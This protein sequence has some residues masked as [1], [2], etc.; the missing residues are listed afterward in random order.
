MSQDLKQL[1]LYLLWSLIFTGVL[2][3][4]FYAR[5]TM[6]THESLSTRTASYRQ[7][8]SCM[9][10][11]VVEKSRFGAILFAV[12]FTTAIILLLR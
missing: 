2:Q 8:S 5:E 7:V 9:E 1:R 4:L 6:R 12:I 10:T 11:S 3:I